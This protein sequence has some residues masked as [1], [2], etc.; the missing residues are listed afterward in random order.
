MDIGTLAIQLLNALQYGLVLFLVASGLT[1]VF[2]ILGVINLAHGAFYMLGAYLA[3][4]FTAST[5]SLAAGILG[6]FVVSFILGLVLE[7]VFIKRLY[8]RDHLSQVLLSFGLIL[9]LDE[10]RQMLFGRD[11]QSVPLPGWL[12]GT[13]TLTDIQSYPHYRLALIVFC[14]LVAVAIF[15]V[16]NRTRIGMIVRAGAENREMTRVLGIPFD[17]V[18]RLVFAVGIALAALAGAVIAP[19]STVFPGMGDGM[20]ILSF[21]VV[22]LGGIGSV[23][24]AAIGALLVGVIDTFGKV[25]LPEIAGMLIYVV[26]AAVLLW[27]PTGILGK[28]EI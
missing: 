2:G 28:R 26:M 1:L 9:V 13:V 27:R 15:L 14:L 8:G 25:F 21:V 23:P 19:V 22:V 17:R 3:W 16:I 6:A 5:G 20:L 12:S 4:W 7:T 11:V 18:N 10:V 24:G